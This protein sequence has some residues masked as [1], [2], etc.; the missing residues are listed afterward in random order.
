MKGVDL[1]KIKY[2]HTGDTS[3]KR[4][5][6]NLEINNKRQDLQWGEIKVKEYG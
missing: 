2:T 1:I 5:N 4:L 6:I 3:R